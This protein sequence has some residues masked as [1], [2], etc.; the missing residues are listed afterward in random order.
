MLIGRYSWTLNSFVRIISRDLVVRRFLCSSGTVWRFIGN[1]V[2]CSQAAAVHP[3]GNKLCLITG[4]LILPWSIVCRIRCSGQCRT[5]QWARASER[6]MSLKSQCSWPQGVSCSRLFH[7][8]QTNLI[9]VMKLLRSANLPFSY[10]SFI[11][12]HL[13]Q[14]ATLC[15]V[16]HN[17]WRQM[18][19]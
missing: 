17:L 13:L 5:K 18:Y 19:M 15:P 11:N 1:S 4:T 10:N 14:M 7:S 2:R 16:W 8:K 3:L 12:R 6:C 9:F